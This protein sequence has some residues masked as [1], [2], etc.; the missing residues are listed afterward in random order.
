MRKIILDISGPLSAERLVSELNHHMPSGRVLDVG[1]G[2]AVSLQILRDNGYEAFGIDRRNVFECSSRPFCANADVRSLPFADKTF[3]AVTE[4]F[5]FAQG[6]EIDNWSEDFYKQ[7]FREIDRVLVPGGIFLSS[8]AGIAVDIPPIGRGIV[9]RF[10][11]GAG[12]SPERSRDRNILIYEK[13][14]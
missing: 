11:T 10:A 7:S 9:N 6:Y 8:W 14:A 12:L 1:T 13:K 3:K 5:M 2:K 4:S